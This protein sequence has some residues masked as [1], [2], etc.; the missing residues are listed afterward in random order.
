MSRG[1]SAI[2]GAGQRLEHVGT[3][4]ADVVGRADQRRVA[5]DR[6]DR[7]ADDRGAG[8]RPL[9]AGDPD[10]AAA[11]IVEDRG[12]RSARR[13]RS[14]TTGPSVG[15]TEMR[16]TGASAGAAERGEVA[17]RPP[18]ADRRRRVQRLG[19]A[20]RGQLG[21]RGARARW[22]TEAAKPSMRTSVSRR[23]H[24]ERREVGGAADTE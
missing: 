20:E 22:A 15:L 19:P 9:P 7:G 2:S 5:A 23:P 10:Q 12:S 16:Q 8:V 24:A 4:Q 3:A 18:R 17:D 21:A 6:G 11:P 13:M 1:V 14:A